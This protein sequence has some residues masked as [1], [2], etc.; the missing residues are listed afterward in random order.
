MDSSRKVPRAVRHEVQT[1]VVSC[2]RIVG[3]WTAENLVTRK[4]VFLLVHQFV[5]RLLLL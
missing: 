5:V 2:S 1:K 3:A 4:F